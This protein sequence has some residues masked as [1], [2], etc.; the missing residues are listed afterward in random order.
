MTRCAICNSPAE[1]QSRDGYRYCINA[2]CFS[3][4]EY[5]TIMYKNLYA[6]AWFQDSWYVEKQMWRT[7]IRNHKFGTKIYDPGTMQYIYQSKK[8]KTWQEIQEWLNKY[9]LLE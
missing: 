4:H 9:G 8:I 2:S 6:D 5:R 1:G 3:L 7:V